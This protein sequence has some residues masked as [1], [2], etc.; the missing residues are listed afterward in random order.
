MDCSTLPGTAATRAVVTCIANPPFD[1]HA[2]IAPGIAAFGVVVAIGLAWVNIRNAR[3]IARLKATLDLIE[4][5][6]SSE[7]YRKRHETFRSIRT[8][9][10]FAALENPG[11]AQTKAQRYEVVEYLNH[12]ELVALG[13]LNRV[14]DE[15]MYRKWMAGPFVRDWNAAAAWIQSERWK[16]E[17]NGMWSYR[18]ATFGNY[19]TMARRW[20]SKATMLT[21]E[22]SPPP[23]AA[24]RAHDGSLGPGDEPLPPTG[25]N[26]GSDA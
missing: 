5:V 4:K 16:L 8:E 2:L 14:L 1:W 7:H 11:D 23:I 22:T 26:A 25:P 20:S 17:D 13:I 9:G 15:G 6:E 18:A 10:R 12:Y 21:R 3:S 24:A 19:Q